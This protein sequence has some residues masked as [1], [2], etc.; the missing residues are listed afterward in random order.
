MNT[1]AKLAITAM[2][3]LLILGIA[4]FGLAHF[5]HINQGT[6]YQQAVLLI[7]KI[8]VVVL[9]GIGTIVLASQVLHTVNIHREV[10]RTF[11]VASLVTIPLATT[12]FL[13][14]MNDTSANNT[15]LSKVYV[16]NVVWL[17]T[18]NVGI[19]AF[20]VVLPFLYYLSRE[21]FEQ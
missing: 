12:A 21:F 5:L 20:I 17:L 6:P 11:W 18:S 19:L 13:K 8:T 9:V 1:Y 2:T 10:K 3:M 14:S 15:T 16:E 4:V 7:S